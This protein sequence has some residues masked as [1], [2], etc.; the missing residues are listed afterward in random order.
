MPTISDL[1][2][3][4]LGELESIQ[5]RLISKD[6]LSWTYQLLIEEYTI[7]YS[8]VLFISDT[9]KTPSSGRYWKQFSLPPKCSLFLQ[10]FPPILQNGP[11]FLVVGSTNFIY[12]WP[13]S[14]W[15]GL[16]V[17]TTS[18]RNVTFHK[19]K[20][21]IWPTLRRVNVYFLVWLWSLFQTVHAAPQGPIR[22]TI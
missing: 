10:R 14:K 13:T 21:R 1:S 6:S 20:E 16:S 12:A 4:V 17:F 8:R 15:V 7:I 11:L 9:R 3:P 2:R 18:L 5:D 19:V 22:N